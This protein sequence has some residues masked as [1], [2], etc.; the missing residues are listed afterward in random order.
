MDAVEKIITRAVNKSHRTWVKRG[1]VEARPLCRKCGVRPAYKVGRV[2]QHCNY[3]KWSSRPGYKEY[4]RKYSKAWH[5]RTYIP[6]PRFKT[7]V[8]LAC[9]LVPP[10]KHQYFCL[11]CIREKRKAVRLLLWAKG[12]VP[13]CKN[14]PTRKVGRTAWAICFVRLCAPCNN[15]RPCNKRHRRRYISEYRKRPIPKEQH[16]WL[17]RSRRLNK[18]IQERKF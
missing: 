6:H 15:A 14:H 7:D 12:Q 11:R 10:Y 5:K 9:K 18:W 16:K 13:T 8:C 2:C 3:L 17:E 1:W 4:H